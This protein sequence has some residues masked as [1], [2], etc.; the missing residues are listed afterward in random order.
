LT[1]QIS[2]ELNTELVDTVVSVLIDGPSR[3]SPNDWQGRG[4]DNRVVNFAKRGA[5]RIGDLVDVRVLRATV[6]SLVGEML[7]PA[8]EP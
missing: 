5:E 1:D 7:P 8:T 6:H 2:L 3:R 4:V